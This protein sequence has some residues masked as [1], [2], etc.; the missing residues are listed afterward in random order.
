M[1]IQTDTS[2]WT[3]YVPCNG[4][5]IFKIIGGRR[6]IAGPF[7]AFTAAEWASTPIPR[8][9]DGDVTPLKWTL[10]RRFIDVAPM[11]SSKV[12]YYTPMLFNWDPSSFWAQIK[13]TLKYPLALQERARNH[14]LIKIQTS[15]YKFN[16]LQHL[17][18]SEYLYY[19]CHAM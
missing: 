7:T 16:A 14:S 17:S 8:L 4:F 6:W 10:R 3:W 5:F 15:T 2:Q 12:A 1:E 11:E 9:C 18:K 19:Y 13:L